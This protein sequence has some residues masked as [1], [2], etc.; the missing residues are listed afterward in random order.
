MPTVFRTGPYR[1]FF[2]SSDNKEPPHIHV[3][4][5]DKRAKFW[6]KPV[7]VQDSGRF[8]HLEISRLH[9]IV[10]DNFDDLQRYWDEFF[11]R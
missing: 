3:E 10:E 8:N 9:R 11:T 7:R 6:L 5:D 2:Y 1:F 4:R